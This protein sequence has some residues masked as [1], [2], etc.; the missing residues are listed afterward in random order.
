LVKGTDSIALAG[1][2]GA[3]KSILAGDGWRCPAMAGDGWRWLAMPGDGPKKYQKN[4]K[5][6]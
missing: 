5:I 3:L 6:D 2:S 1:L 4:I